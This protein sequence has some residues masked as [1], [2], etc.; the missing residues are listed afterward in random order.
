[1]NKLFIYVIF[2]SLL[3]SNTFIGDVGQVDSGNN[4]VE[5]TSYAVK[6]SNFPTRNPHCKYRIWYVDIYLC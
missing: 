5:R 6:A 2:S 3:F 1:M 4:H